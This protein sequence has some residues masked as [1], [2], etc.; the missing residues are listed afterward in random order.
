MPRGVPLSGWT[1][2]RRA[3]YSELMKQIRKAKFWSNGSFSKGNQHL[4]RDTRLHNHVVSEVAKELQ[5]QGAR[6][7]FVDLPKCSRPDIIF[8]EDGK[9]YLWD[10]KTRNKGTKTWCEGEA[11]NL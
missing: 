8:F 4:V 11:I 9:L 5:K 10:I 6:L 3:K 1:P 7:I 2:E